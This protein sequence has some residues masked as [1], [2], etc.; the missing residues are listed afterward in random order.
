[1]LVFSSNPGRVVAEIPVTLPMPRNRLDPAFRQMVDDIYAL[2]TARPAG[3]QAQG[4]FPGTG[5]SMLLPRVSPNLMAGLMETLAAAPYHGHADLPALA[6]PLHMEIDDL[7]PVAET[8]QLM[9]FAEL[10][11]GDLRLTEAG[12]RFVELDPD[13]RKRLFAQHLLAYVPLAGHIRRVLDERGNHR[14]PASRFRDELEDHM[15]EQFADQTL[16]SVT[17]WGRYA[18]SFAYDEA[19]G[20]FS[21][22]N[23]S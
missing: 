20:V 4:A 1:I 16:R 22:D 23:P 19:T 8:L 14:A 11:E 3:K 18:E 12:R 10:A 2:M 7:F 21:L 13:G 5:I 9:R 6:G 15:S 17:S